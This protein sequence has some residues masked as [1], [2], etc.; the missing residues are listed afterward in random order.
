MHE[1]PFTM[2]MLD[3]VLEHARAANASKV[4]KIDL[5]IGKLTGIVPECIQSQFDVLKKDT[6]AKEAELSFHQPE[7]KLRC[8]H[9]DIIYTPDKRDLKCP[10]CGKKNMEVIAGREYYVESI[11]VE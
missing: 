7:N 6:I 9:C 8:R 11:E 3:I 4:T 1:L 2:S 5:V 10:K